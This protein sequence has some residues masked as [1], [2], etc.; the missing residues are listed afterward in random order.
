MRLSWVH[1]CF[2]PSY[3]HYTRGVKFGV[4]VFGLPCCD[5]EVVVL[6]TYYLSF[7]YHRDP[8]PIT[9]LP[10]YILFG[11]IRLCRKECAH[12]YP[13]S[14]FKIFDQVFRKKSK[15][16]P[17]T[18]D[19]RCVNEWNKYKQVLLER[20]ESM[21]ETIH[22]GW[23]VKSPPDKKSQSLPRFFQAVSRHD[24]HRI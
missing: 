5:A 21:G 4:E 23:L 2:N 19:C 16:Y 15:K 14:C 10:V 3:W 13:T 7:V 6:V 24:L 20:V 22:E 8:P 11:T 1:P 17:T 18:K 9:L 12:Y